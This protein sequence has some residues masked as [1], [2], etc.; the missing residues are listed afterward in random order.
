MGLPPSPSY[1]PRADPLCTPRCHRSG[2]SRGGAGRTGRLAAAA[3][4]RRHKETT[5][6]IR[7]PGMASHSR[8]L[9]VAGLSYRPEPIPPFSLAP[10]PH[11]LPWPRRMSGRS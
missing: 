9:P 4:A 2:R 1:E 10:R 11:W 8:G 7:P 6:R 3:P 5:G